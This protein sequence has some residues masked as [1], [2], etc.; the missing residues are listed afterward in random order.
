MA[1]GRAARMLA[2][3]LPKSHRVVVVD[4]NEYVL[5]VYNVQL[6]LTMPR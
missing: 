6:L 5:A 4:K 3:G 1:G 2:Q